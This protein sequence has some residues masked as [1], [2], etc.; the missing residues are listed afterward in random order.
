MDSDKS[1]QASKM[2]E[3]SRG[4]EINHVRIRFIQFYSILRLKI[5]AAVWLL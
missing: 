4:R 3:N 2:R 1:Y 5:S